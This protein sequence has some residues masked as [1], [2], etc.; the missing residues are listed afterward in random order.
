[1]WLLTG[2][3]DRTCPDRVSAAIQIREVFGMREIGVTAE[4]KCGHK[5]LISDFLWSS[6]TA[7]ALVRAAFEP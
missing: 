3:S 5:G 1:M 2:L 6:R 4:R 7:S